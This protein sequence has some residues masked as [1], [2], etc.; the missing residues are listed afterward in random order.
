MQVFWG[1][2][3]A[4]VYLPR[5]TSVVIVQTI[6]TLCV[7]ECARAVF[8]CLLRLWLELSSLFFFCLC[9]FMKQIG[10]RSQ[11]STNC[12]LK[13]KHFDLMGMCFKSFPKI[14]KYVRLNIGEMCIKWCRMHPEYF[15]LMEWCS[16]RK[17]EVLGVNISLSVNITELQ[18]RVGATWYRIYRI[19]TVEATWGKRGNTIGHGLHLHNSHQI[20]ISQQKR[21]I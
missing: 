1:N 18:W 20:Y 17:H 3:T 5:T 16:L 7:Q 12:S 21:K 19:Q 8:V 11:M 2:L 10:Q 4:C 14:L 13:W 6:A 9:T 15:C